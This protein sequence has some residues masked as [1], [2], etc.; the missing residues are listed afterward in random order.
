MRRILLMLLLSLLLTGTVFAADGVQ[1]QAELLQTERLYQGL[2]AETR[3]QLGEVRPGQS[4]E[5]GTSLW[6]LVSDAVS[7][8]LGFSSEALGAAGALLAVTLLCGLCGSMD[9]PLSQTAVRVVGA[10]GITA[11]STVSLRT[12][13]GLATETLQRIGDFTTLLLPVLSSVLTAAG[14]I[15]SGSALYVGSSLFFDVLVRLVRTLL[16]PLVYAFLALSAAECAA[17][18]GRLAPVRDL[19]GWVIQIALKGVVYLFTAYLALTGVVTGGADEATLRA[20]KA[21]L[22][23]AIPVVGGIVS[24]ASE[25]VLASASVLKNTTG[26]FGLLAV[27]AIGLTPFL[28]IGLHYLTMKLT[29]ALSGALG[30]EAHT[31]LLGS[32]A[33][34]MGYLLGM[35][36]SCM[37]MALFS[38]CCFLKAV[39]G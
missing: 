3:A 4:A 24:E 34:A 28:R 39:G 8:V 13:V 12:M 33:T 17:G 11:A 5:L 15:A 21:A 31:K 16:L 18:E 30:S 29:A 22:S 10:L 20:A 27:L 9:L 14:G 37:L 35:T 36:G 19:I 6:R 32:I 38:C 25:S 23:G 7:S 1:T 26:I 2:D